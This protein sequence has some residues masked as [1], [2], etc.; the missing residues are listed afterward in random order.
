MVYSPSFK[1]LV[2]LTFLVTVLF[3]NAYAQ[4]DDDDEFI[5]D[6]KLQECPSESLIHY[7]DCQGALQ[8]CSTCLGDAERA[9]EADRKRRGLSKSICID[10]TTNVAGRC[11]SAKPMCFGNQECRSDELCINFGCAPNPS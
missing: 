5:D 3:P 2:T 11:N 8:Q 10:C 6:Y 9:C 7:R 4:Y 1:I